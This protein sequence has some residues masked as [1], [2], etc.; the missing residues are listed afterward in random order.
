MTS[1]HELVVMCKEAVARFVNHYHNTFH[2][3][4]RKPSL[5]TLVNKILAQERFIVFLT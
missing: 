5:I 4:L 1:D 2:I 3:E